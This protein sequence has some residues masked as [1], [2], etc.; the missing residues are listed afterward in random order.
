MPFHAVFPCENSLSAELEMPLPEPTQLAI[1]PKKKNPL[2]VPD[3]S[4]YIHNTFR[5]SISNIL[6][7]QRQKRA[8]IKKLSMIGSNYM[9][10]DTTKKMSYTTRH[11]KKGLLTPKIVCHKHQIKTNSGVK[12]KRFE[13]KKKK[14]PRFAEIV[15]QTKRFPQI[16][17]KLNL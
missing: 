13:K 14:K 7:W 12:R 10:N 9:M 1:F 16:K 15:Q 11:R 3:T 4:H 8:S 17:D 5:Y 6:I 2:L